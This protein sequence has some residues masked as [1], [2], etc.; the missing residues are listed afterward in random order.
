MPNYGLCNTSSRFPETV[1]GRPERT[2]DNGSTQWFELAVK[3]RHDKAV[4]RTLE[5]SVLLEI[6]GDQVRA[7]RG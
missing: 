2:P 5:R 7:E 3:P 4:A 1:V 6:D